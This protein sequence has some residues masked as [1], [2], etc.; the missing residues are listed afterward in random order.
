MHMRNAR[1]KRQGKPWITSG[2]LKSINVKNKLYFKT[3][4]ECFNPEI[5]ERYNRYK[6]MLDVL[7]KI[8][9]KSYFEHK[10]T[11]N[12]NNQKKTWQTINEALNRKS[13]SNDNV[14][15]QINVSVE[16][17]QSKVTNVESMCK[18]F[19]DFFVKVGQSV[20]DSIQLVGTEKPVHDYLGPRVTQSIF[21]EPVTEGELLSL[22][23]RQKTNKSPGADFIHPK[24]LKDGKNIIV[25]PLAHIFNLS[26]VSGKFPNRMK[27]A[28]VIPIFKGG[29]TEDL[30][31]YRPISVLSAVSKLLERLVASRVLKFLN[32]N[33][34]FYNLQFG[35]RKNRSTKTAICE[36]TNFVYQ[37]LEEGNINLGIFLD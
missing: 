33:A 14:P 22:L 5:K 20:S 9:E 35:F 28:R 23:D 7:L 15:R 16:G 12:Q 30:S 21:L 4:H 26:I 10:F 32:K 1:K 18:H 8:A 11:E 29:N 25:K 13:A 34:L 19:N 24:L 27:I 3:C 2:L 31:N 36:F 6:N 37:Q 17:N